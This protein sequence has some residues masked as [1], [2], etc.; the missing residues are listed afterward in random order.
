MSL[1]PFVYFHIWTL[2][3]HAVDYFAQSKAIN[4]SAVP[5]VW[6]L[7]L[8]YSNVASFKAGI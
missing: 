1:F 4:I 6:Q 8:L 5:S 2:L 3:H 7:S